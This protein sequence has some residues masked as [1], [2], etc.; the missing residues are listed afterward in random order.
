M[1]DLNIFLCLVILKIGQ[2]L[3]SPVVV[4]CIGHIV[5]WFFS[6]VANSLAFKES[7]C[8]DFP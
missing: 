2:K 7:V 8:Q 5:F 4:W 1:L 6:E 3:S